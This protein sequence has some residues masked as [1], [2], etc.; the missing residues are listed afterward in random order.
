MMIDRDRLMRIFDQLGQ[1]LSS[2]ATICVIGSTPGII[3]GQPDRQSQDI[4]VWRPN[5]KYDETQFRRACQELGLL[6]DPRGELDPDA[7]YVQIVRPG[8]VNL[9]SDFKLEILG[10]Y[11]VLTVAMPNPALL[12]AAKLVRG[13]PRDIEDV[14]WWAKERALDLDELRAA[15]GTL[16][17]V[18]QREAAA[19]N[20][21]LVGLVTP[22][23]R[24]PK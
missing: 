19:E 11:G 3:L 4:D 16:P 8:L 9:P 18:T 24:A 20:M 17:D 1:R 2:A 12:S 21:V 10:E 7:I 5:S 6:Y 23:G 13:D 22:S 14:A 15:V